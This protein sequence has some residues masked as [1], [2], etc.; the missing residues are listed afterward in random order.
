MSQGKYS[1]RSMVV[2]FVSC[3]ITRTGHHF[4]NEEINSER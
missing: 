1:R 3:C 4:E 2:S